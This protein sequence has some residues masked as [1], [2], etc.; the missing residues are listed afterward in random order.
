MKLFI[1]K[2]ERERT[3]SEE[4]L[5]S[6]DRA[7]FDRQYRRLQEENLTLQRQIE[8]LQSLL[9]DVEQQHAQR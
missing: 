6:W 8:H 9:N 3:V 1:S 7:E 5:R 2:V 4:I